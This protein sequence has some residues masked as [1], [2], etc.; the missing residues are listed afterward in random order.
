MDAEPG[1]PT[2]LRLAGRRVLVVGGGRVAA[3]RVGVLL[4]AGA[5][6]DVVAPEIGEDLTTLAIEGR[7][8][9]QQRGFARDDVMSPEPAWLVHAATDSPETNSAAADSSEENRIWCIRAD[10]ARASAAWTP[11]VG[12][13]APGTPAQGVTIAVSGG[14]DP[15]RAAAVRDAVIAGL[16]SGLLPVRRQRPGH[17]RARTVGRVALVGGG[18]GH[19]DLITVRGRQLLATA[20]VVV[21]DRLGPRELLDGLSPEVE[22]V[23]VGKTPGHHPISQSRI[24]E[25][26][27]EHALAGRDVVRLKGGDPFVLG[28]GAEEAIHCAARGVPVEVV[29]GVT[30]A[31]AVPAA[32]GI[33]VTHRGITGSFVVASAHDGATSAHDALRDA[34]VTSTVV[35]LMG[36]AALAEAAERLIASGRRGTTPVAIIE[37]GWSPEQRTTVTTLETAAETADREG[38][39]SPAVIVVGDVVSVRA[40]VGDLVPPDLLAARAP[41]LVLLAHGSTDPRHARG[42]EA[43]AELVRRRWAGQVHTAYLD[44][45]A[46]SPADVASRVE[47]GVLVPLLLTTAHH[48]R[49]D[50]PAAAEEM[51][52]VGR[53]AFPVAASLGPDPLLFEAAE[54][55]LARAGFGPDPG[56]A[57]VLFAGGS[58][59]YKAI[60]AIGD[61]IADH[62]TPGWGP[63]AVAALAGGDPIADVVGRLRTDGVER[64]LVVTYLIAGGMLRDRMV[65]HSLAVGAVVVPG[66][67][68]GTDAL[69]R[70][71]VRR[72]EQAR[73]PGTVPDRHRL[74][75]ACHAV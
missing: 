28:R 1:Y 40:Q 45:H 37:A 71:V 12:R 36:V 44:H 30:S 23:D 43:V 27:V 38:V 62:P 34:P 75:G 51:D 2:T 61:A 24:N 32:A 68:G 18:P 57:V 17:T 25:I 67:L 29:P 35:L 64:V 31:V 69:A 6:V 42:V 10:D 50:V 52:A 66:T 46:P 5:L 41:N 59:D 11:A 56:T 48:V 3:G 4:D 9:W 63:W 7:I 55:L 8:R 33:P 60:T 47:G 74:R 26:L 53:G 19:P 13:G 15:R 65:E 22:V 21:A 14:G 39:R 20:D 72:A 58:S 16:A 54:E 73:A 49:T 70:L